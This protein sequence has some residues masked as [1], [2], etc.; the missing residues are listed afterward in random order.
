MCCKVNDILKD[1]PS[2]TQ[3]IDFQPV[4]RDNLPDPIGSLCSTILRHAVT[5]ATLGGYLAI[6]EEKGQL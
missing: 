4:C 1:S 6:A 3:C 2:S 5:E